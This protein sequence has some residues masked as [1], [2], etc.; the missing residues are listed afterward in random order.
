MQN[1]P[2]RWEPPAGEKRYCTE[3][4][5]HSVTLFMR[6]QG[7]EPQVGDVC[8]RCFR[9]YKQVTANSYQWLVSGLELM[10]QSIGDERL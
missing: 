7:Y 6:A 9:T 10:R 2:R 1:S 8:A 3:C 4:Q 5:Y